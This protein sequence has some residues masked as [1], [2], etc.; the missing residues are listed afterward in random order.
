ME[1]FALYLLKSACW[2]TG[3][4]LVYYLFLQNERFFHLKRFYLIAGILVSVFFPFI[5]V[6]YALEAPVIESA[7]QAEPVSIPSAIISRA[8]SLG[9]ESPFD[10]RLILLFLYVAGILYFSLKLILQASKLLIIIKKADVGILGKARLVRASGIPYSFSFFN[11]IF[12]NNS[13][14]EI[15]KKEILHHEFVHI[16][17]KHWFD[18]LL[19]DLLCLVQWANPFAWIYTRFIKLNHEYLADELA[20]ERTDN[21]AVYKA[22][23]VNQIFNKPVIS[24]SNAFNYSINE[25][26]FNMMK[27][28]FSSPYRKLRVLAVLPIFLIVFYAFATPEYHYNKTNPINSESLAGSANNELVSARETTPVEDQKITKGVVLKE[29]GT[30]FQGVQIA[31]TGTE[32]RETT[33]EKGNFK[34]QNI[35][36]DAFLV[37]S[38]RGYITQVLKPK[39][40]DMSVKLL[41]DTSKPAVQISSQIND[42][43][44]VIDGIISEKPYEQAR[45]EINTNE[46]ATLRVL[47]EKDG[48]DKYG[49]KAKTRVIEIIT[50][51]KAAELG[52]KVPFRRQKPEDYPTFQ[53][54]PA[55]GFSDYLA[56]VIKYPADAAAK[57]IKGRASVNFIIQ[58]DGSTNNVRVTGASDPLLAEAV[59]K[60]VN[61][62]PRWDPAKNPEAKD[63]YPSTATIKFELPDKVSTD[64]TYY[65]VEQMPEYPGGS[66]ALVDFI[67]THLRYPEA[68]REQ[69]IEGRVIV[70][71]IVNHRGLVEDVEILKS[72]HPLLDAEAIRVVGELSGWLPGAQGGRPVNTWYSIPVTFSLSPEKIVPTFSATTSEVF[73]VVEKMPKYPGGEE[74]LMKAINDELQ[75]PEEAKTQNIQGRVIVRF[76]VGTDGSVLNAEVIKSA[77]PLLDAEALRVIKKLSGFEPGMQG[78]VAVNVYYAIPVTFALK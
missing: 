60:A 71:F 25:Q 55:S 11:Y 35:P 67:K 74:A 56:S 58:P 77:H 69:K 75:Y 4:A 49:D 15:E 45:K 24:L 32:I 34:L 9:H 1:T 53:G 8:T 29:D 22:A 40:S 63:P 14:S 68:A 50:N 43:L 27:K 36:S 5:N 44:V 65:L 38:F 47:S 7:L 61:E 66:T 37:F 30:A 31:V 59:V 10:F 52:I 73:V 13:V 51:K 72:V 2:L 39:S 21:Q 12:M 3:F 33:D 62:S 19:I 18:L 70:R 26:R 48:K 57:G 54:K 6:H 46:I 20:L 23:L 42:A 41:K 78:G 17:Q 16:Q 28:I 76:I 64:D